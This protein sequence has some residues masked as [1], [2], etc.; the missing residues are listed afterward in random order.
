MEN[1]ALSLKRMNKHRKILL[2]G[3]HA[4]LQVFLS[5]KTALCDKQIEI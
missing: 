5:N 2:H 4:K 1:G 3:V